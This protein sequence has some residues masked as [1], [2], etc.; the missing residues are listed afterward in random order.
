[1]T[2]RSI[3]FER[4]QAELPGEPDYFADLNLDQV[5]DSV[6]SGR[7]E[8]DL[9]PFF[10]APLRDTDSIRYRH[11]VFRDLEQA[12]LFEH[13][14]SFGRQM[15]DMREQ[16]ARATKMYYKYQKERWFVEA[17]SLYCASV[18][19]LAR[20]LA[21]GKLASR[22][23]RALREYLADYIHSAPFIELEAETEQLLDQLST[24]KYSL[25]IHE[26]SIHVQKY[27]GQSDY[28]AE[29][30]RTFEKFKSGAAK[31]VH[32]DFSNGL[33]MNHVEAGILDLVAQLYPEA[34]SHLDDYA[35]KHAG[36]L[37][38][39]IARFDRE[40]QFYLSYLDFLAPMKQAGLRFCQPH[41]SDHDKAV[42]SREGFDLA[43]ADKLTSSHAPVVTNDLY[44][45]GPERIFVVSGP[46][47]GGK[48]T[49]ARTFGQLHHLA[50]LGCP[51]PG[52]EA[53]LFLF[54]RLFTHFEKEE[55]ITNLRGKLQ[56]DLA[57]IHHVLEQ[58]APQSIIIMNEIFTST[59]LEDAVFLSKQV[60]E[61]IMQL[62]CLSVCVTFIDELASLGEKTVS[63][64]STVVPEDPAQRTYKIVRRSADGLSYALAIAEKYRLTYA[65][66]KERI[67]P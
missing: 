4:P 2:F 22:G 37:D 57:R 43:L 23:F 64:V 60:M 49:F 15:R 53:T 16:L 25:L 18:Q 24:V 45:D 56:D 12:T 14:K 61:R 26:R 51:V 55:D 66:L 36:Y 27:A 13:L 42:H 35:M 62:D 9:K 50:A 19:T 67:Q 34:F 63:V 40:I 46:N 6:A 30:E 47:Q 33:E 10:Y 28:S 3:L 29:V 20:D 8:Y 7:Q 54:D 48:T 1:M 58:A 5:V 59:T 21:G 17:V 52:R 39:T 31:E 44:L 11:Q 38:E 41:V 65:S 32:I